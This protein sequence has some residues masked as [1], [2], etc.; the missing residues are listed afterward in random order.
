[1]HQ[2]AD[3]A[4]TLQRAMTALTLGRVRSP[5][6]SVLPLSPINS[7]LSSLPDEHVQQ[8]PRQHGVHGM[9]RRLLHPDHRQHSV[10]RLRSYVRPLCLAW[11]VLPGRRLE[12]A[13]RLTYAYPPGFH[14]FLS[15]PPAACAAGS[16]SVG[17]GAAC[18]RTSSKN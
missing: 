7:T 1:M 13:C 8:Q 5:P 9:L 3:E 14:T 11:V 2:Y 16:F 4:S 12:C 10:E 15:I 6:V 18:Q 17:G